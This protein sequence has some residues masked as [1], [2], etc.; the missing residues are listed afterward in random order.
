M[1]ILGLI[2]SYESQYDLIIN[3][4]LIITTHRVRTIQALREKI[5]RNRNKIQN[6]QPW[7][8]VCQFNGILWDRII[9]RNKDGGTE[10]G[11][12]NR[13]T[14]DRKIIYILSGILCDRNAT[15]NKDGGLQKGIQNR[16]PR[17]TGLQEE[18]LKYN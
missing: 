6:I 11:I 10:K 14:Q 4:N 8:T 7:K 13:N 1:K 16:K 3:N 2:A 17:N 15:R 5:W 18:Y 9:A 12:Q